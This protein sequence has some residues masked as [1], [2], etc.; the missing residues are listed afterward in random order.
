[1]HDG[2]E[3]NL[4]PGLVEEALRLELNFTYPLKHVAELIVSGERMSSVAVDKFDVVGKNIV[5][6]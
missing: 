4:Y 3:K 6:G 2:T 1:M 5:N